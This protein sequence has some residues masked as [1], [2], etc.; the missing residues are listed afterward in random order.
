[1]TGK[2]ILLREI[3]VSCG[4][5]RDNERRDRA[6]MRDIGPESIRAYDMGCLERGILHLVH[7]QTGVC[8]R[9]EAEVGPPN[10][11]LYPS[12]WKEK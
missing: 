7:G 11:I 2:L 6:A 12:T 9:P 5:A 3:G 4:N 10:W 8:S 1:V